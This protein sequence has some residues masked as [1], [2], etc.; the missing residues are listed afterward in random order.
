[1]SISHQEQAQGGE[2]AS[3]EH[4]TL[5]YQVTSTR[6]D[7][8]TTLIWQTLTVFLGLSGVGLGILASTD[9]DTPDQIVLA[10][11]VAIAVTFTLA[12]WNNAA[13]KWND[14][15]T[16]MYM[17]LKEI[18]R[19]LHLRT[20]LAIDQHDED[21]RSQGKKTVSIKKMRNRLVLWISVGWNLYVV[22]RAIMAYIDQE[23]MV[24]ASQ[25]G[26]DWTTVQRNV[27]SLVA[28]CSILIVAGL[29]MRSYR[30]AFGSLRQ[31]IHRK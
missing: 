26:N 13:N 25:N 11:V 17:R 21:L 19:E 10:S 29:L 31:R 24:T 18:E 16:A 2:H 27:V 12:W 30:E 28:I 1:M 20:N 9:I 8:L 3:R 7:N 22:L 14:Y 15:Q 4:L 23:Q 5:E 6:V